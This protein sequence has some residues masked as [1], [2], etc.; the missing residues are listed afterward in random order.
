VQSVS[1]GDFRVIARLGRGGMAD[2]FL[3]MRRGPAGFSK[4]VVI[5]QL[6][7]DLAALAEGPSYRTL[8]LDEAKLAARLQHPNIVQTFEVGE[9]EA[10]GAPMSGSYGELLGGL[11]Y[12]AMEYLDGQPLDRV[13]VA[14]QKAYVVVPVEIVLRLIADVVAGL[15][16]AH[17]LCDYDGTPLGI[18]HRDVSPHNVFWTYQGEI[19]LVDFGVAKYAY[20]AETE[21]GMVKGKLSYMAPEQAQRTGLDHRADLFPA[22]ILLW[23]CL[24]SRPLMPR[25][26]PAAAIK[27]L[28]YEPLPSLAEVRP[29]LPP[30]LTAICDRALQ[31]DPA[32]RYQS[33]RE[34]REDLERLLGGG[35]P[36]R[37]ELSR[38]VQRLFERERATAAQ[39]LRDAM[40]GEDIVDLVMTRRTTTAGM[41]APTGSELRGWPQT[42]THT[43]T[44]I[45]T[46]TG[47][48]P[49]ARASSVMT[50]GE[51]SRPSGARSAVLRNTG[52]LSGA[53]PAMRVRA[54]TGEPGYEMT[55]PPLPAYVAQVQPYNGESMQ[56]LPLALPPP[57]RWRA[58]R[59]TVLGLGLGL[60]AAA[61]IALGAS[62]ARS[63]DADP[64]AGAE[65]E[66]SSDRSVF[67]RMAATRRTPA[68]SDGPATSPATSSSAASSAA[69]PGAAT[70]GA[71]PAASVLVEDPTA[72]GRD[73][74][75]AG[76]KVAL[77]LCGSNTIGAELAPALIEEF[78]AHK[79]GTDVARAVVGVERRRVFS[80]ELG[81][82][83]ALIEIDARGSATAF[84]ALAKGHCD[85][86]MSS[87]P[88]DDAEAAALQ[89]A[90]AGELR[91]PAAEHVVALDG[92]S[93]I[94]HPN[95]PLR[96]L[97][98]KALRDVFTG[99]ITDWSELGGPAGRI[100]V[101][102]R[103][104]RS[105]TFETF[106]QLVLGKD[107]LRAGARR[108]ADSEA[109]S[110]AVA[111]S[112]QAIGFV[113]L[114]YVRSARAL[115]V[116]EPGATPM[117]PT[118]FTVATEAYLLSR[119]LYFYLPARSSSPLASEL[120]AFAL[121]PRGQTAVGKAQFVDLSLT[122]R[123]QACDLRC[124][125]AYAAVVSGAQRVSVDLR[126]LSG[127]NQPDSRA[128]RDLDRLV[129][130][131][132]DHPGSRL[133]LVGFSDS[134]GSVRT[135]AR[136]SLERAQAIER[137]L[138][139][140]GLQP[141]AV[142]GFGAA[143]PVASNST[144]S[145]RERNRR[146]EVWLAR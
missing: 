41:M 133:I 13:L 87:R 6:R 100:E 114:A 83:P 7:D 136:I 26:N 2:V 15:E 55:L 80:A 14:A 141:Q 123:D 146:V 105:G 121:S 53:R 84:A 132:H 109:L 70:S 124:P 28:L 19:K 74:T 68:A 32:L 127:S 108:F 131:A 111:R 122:L 143:L 93:V 62:G 115:A 34:M 142:R 17:E 38:F 106:R 31:R 72:A 16:Y 66:P 76:R 94:V 8:L 46:Q 73:A 64:S 102:A 29:D 33:A 78:L 117:L 25:N 81:G 119:R 89:R 21:A 11:P 97:D 47:T 56:P 67:A 65:A 59:F 98:R 60:A 79:G 99:A 138:V 116:S 12:L 42:G 43:G 125:R 44:H 90:G 10:S 63:N 134:L 107:A 3:A 9:I 104:E 45:G 92:I 137:E 54:N 75:V 1:F 24:A 129:A 36:Q 101:I 49:S 112:P 82:V 22:G 77:R 120:V 23:E 103:D 126:F 118:P 18:V 27:R 57:D 88:I 50:I 130:L 52:L 4:L 61:M 37:S 69:S 144:E 58:A 71:R 135:N 128:V 140:R 48:H 145:G 110:D 91:S 20:S 139:T 85:L 51:A 95:N 5:K 39:Q 30:Q 96:A 86:G 113:G 35:G 40:T